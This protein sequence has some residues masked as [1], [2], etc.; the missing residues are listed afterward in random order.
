[1]DTFENFHRILTFDHPERIITRPPTYEVFHHGYD[2]EGF[3][4]GGDSSPAG[5]QWV[6]ILNPFRQ[7]PMTWIKSGRSPTGV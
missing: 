7:L 4:G 5:T 2:H 3:E 6:D 1:M